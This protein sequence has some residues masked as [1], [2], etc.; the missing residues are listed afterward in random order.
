MSSV[1]TLYFSVNVYFFLC[2]CNSE[3]KPG[4]KTW[5]WN[6]TLIWSKHNSHIVRNTKEAAWMVSESN[7][8][9]TFLFWWLLINFARRHDEKTPGC[10]QGCSSQCFSSLATRMRVCNIVTT[11]SRWW[12]ASAL[13]ACWLD[14]T[15]RQ[16]NHRFFYHLTTFSTLLSSTSLIRNLVFFRMFFRRTKVYSP[17]WEGGERRVC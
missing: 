9:R 15:C 7:C 3:T 5:K 10:F 6:N 2:D 13:M 4:W 1:S 16:A 17:Q 8:W 14:Y 12:N 11:C